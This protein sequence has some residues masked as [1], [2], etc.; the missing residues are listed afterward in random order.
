[1]CTSPRTSAIS[2][3][4]GIGVSHSPRALAISASRM[5]AITSVS[6]SA[7]WISPSGTMRIGGLL[8]L[9]GGDFQAGGNNR[10]GKIEIVLHDGY[11]DGD[12]FQVGLAGRSE[13][14]A[15]RSLPCV[16]AERDAAEEVPVGAHFA[17]LL[18]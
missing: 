6:T 14:D 16:G 15:D 10:V 9:P 5:S 1:M 12:R 2:R 13:V 17:C 3:C 4:M 18:L 8:P 7:D 11:E